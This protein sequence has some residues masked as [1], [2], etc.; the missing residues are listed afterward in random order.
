MNT[1]IFTF[2]SPRHGST[3]LRE[4][5]EVYIRVSERLALV[6]LGGFIHILGILKGK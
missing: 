5:S 3:L 1:L 4:A 6:D 2:H